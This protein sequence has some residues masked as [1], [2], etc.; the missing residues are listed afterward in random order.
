MGLEK[1]ATMENSREPD[2]V[3]D[4][5]VHPLWQV[6]VVDGQFTRQTEMSDP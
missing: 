3:R 5:Y 1:A 2:A 6:G 4:A